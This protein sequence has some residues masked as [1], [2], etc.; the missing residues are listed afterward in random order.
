VIAIGAI[1]KHALPICHTCDTA[2]RL[3]P[4][5]AAQNSSQEAQMNS[6]AMPA[7]DHEPDMQ[8]AHQRKKR[9]MLRQLGLAD[10]FLEP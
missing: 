9:A 2:S 7:V 8:Q 6:N 5:R 10:R 3:H 1:L 4:S